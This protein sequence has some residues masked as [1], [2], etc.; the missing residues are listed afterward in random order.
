MLNSILDVVP[1]TARLLERLKG[2]FLPLN[3]VYFERTSDFRG[4]FPCGEQIT[5]SMPNLS[6]V[7]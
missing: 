7:F 4:V 6:V 3:L 2:N 5:P 1:G